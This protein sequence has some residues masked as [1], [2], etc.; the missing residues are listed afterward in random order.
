[1]DALLIVAAVEQPRFNT[2]L[3]E[4][5]LIAA[6]RGDMK[7]VLVINKTDLGRL[8]DESFADIYQLLHEM[9]IVYTSATTGRGLVE[10]REILKGRRCV[11][12]GARVWAKARW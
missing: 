6:K 8:V 11:L 2:G 7:P 5:F 3:I 10:L 4:R 1:M 9:Q 12:T